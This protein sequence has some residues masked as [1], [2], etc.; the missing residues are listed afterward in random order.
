MRKPL[1]SPGPGSKAHCA[2]RSRTWARQRWPSCARKF[3][4]I[5][6]ALLSEIV[7]DVPAIYA[8]YLTADDMRA[9]AAF[10]S[11]PTGAKMLQALP[12][13]LPEAFATVLPRMQSMAGETQESFLKL[14]R[15]RGVL[16]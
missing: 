11:T 14:L 2:P 15:E 10:Y 12:K 1:R 6:L 13:F 7:K 3:E 16:Q 5:R 8:R 4:R 9:L